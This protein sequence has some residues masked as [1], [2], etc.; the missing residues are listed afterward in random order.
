[1]RKLF[2]FVLCVIGFISFAIAK[3]DV[4]SVTAKSTSSTNAVKSVN[5]KAARDKKTPSSKN[6]ILLYDGPAKGMV[7]AFLDPNMRLIPI[8]QQGNWVKVGNPKDGQ[9]G[10]INL[11][12]Y[13]KARY[14]YYRPNIQ[15]LFVHLTNQAKGK[16][17]LNIVAYRNGKQLSKK[18]AAA[19]YNRLRKQQEKQFR[20]MQRFSAS[21]ERMMD[22]DFLNAAQF[23]DTSWLTPTWMAPVILIQQPKVKQKEDAASQPARKS[24][25]KNQSV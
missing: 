7:L 13:Q 8:Y 19:I 22:Q 6:K 2:A 5:K 15:T 23:F 9:V 3:A 11:I 10:W 4:Q 17:T 14:A 18:E 20:T 25:H 16:P 12:Q 21:M 1:M 24:M